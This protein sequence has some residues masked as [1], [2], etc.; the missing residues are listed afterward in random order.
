MNRF[1]QYQVIRFA[2]TD[3]LSISSSLLYIVHN[4]LPLTT[5]YNILKGPALL[6]KQYCSHVGCFGSACWRL[7]GEKKLQ[8]NKRDD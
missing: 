8:K 4:D 6:L 7:N 5:A 3:S 1:N 2:K